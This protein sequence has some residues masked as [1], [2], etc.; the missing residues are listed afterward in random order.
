MSKRRTLLDFAFRPDDALQR[1]L[2]EQILAYVRAT[3]GEASER[4]EQVHSQEQA[5]G[6]VPIGLLGAVPGGAIPAT[7]LEG[8]V[9]DIAGT[10]ARESGDL[11]IQC[12]TEDRILTTLGIDT[13]G[14]LLQEKAPLF[15]ENERLVFGNHDRPPSALPRNAK[16]GWST[17]RRNADQLLTS[18]TP[19]QREAGEAKVAIARHLFSNFNHAGLLL[20]SQERYGVT[21][22]ELISGIE[23]GRTR[24]GEGHGGITYD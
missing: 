2:R 15:K 22:G 20:L 24:L 1:T 10:R 18:L 16:A 9:G 8:L 11:A 13:L 14:M 5:I 12:L 4:S 7:L 17:F 19:L 3:V 23:S 6:N 21:M